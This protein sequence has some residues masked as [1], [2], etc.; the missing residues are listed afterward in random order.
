MWTNLEGRLQLAVYRNAFDAH[1]KP[2]GNSYAVRD[3]EAKD[4]LQAAEQVWHDFIT[5]CNE[6]CGIADRPAWAFEPL[7]GFQR[8]RGAPPVSV[9]QRRHPRATAVERAPAAPPPV[10]TLP[11]LAITPAS[12]AAVHTPFPALPPFAST[13]APLSSCL[14]PFNFDQH[15]VPHTPVKRPLAVID[16]SSS[17]EEDL[18]PHKRPFNVDQHYILHTPVKRPLAV[19]DISSSDDEDLHP[20]KRPFHLGTVDLTD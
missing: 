13:P 14:R 9:A 6:D 19:I 7:P 15:Y 20:R 8:V 4:A 16:I 5:I 17:D 2:Q 18:R 1:F 10:A 12:G 11:P 3:P